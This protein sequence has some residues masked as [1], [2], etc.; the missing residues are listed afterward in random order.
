MDDLKN[1][2]MVWIVAIFTAL[3]FCFFVVSK[4]L[5]NKTADKVIEKL[6]KE[7]SP[8]PYGP[9]IDPDKV[10][11]DA[12]KKQRLYFEMRQNENGPYTSSSSQNVSWRDIWEQDRGFSPEQ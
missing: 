5:V 1:N 12:M 9:G 2:K 6:Q 10:N 7:Y 4:V 3:N 8:S 11:P